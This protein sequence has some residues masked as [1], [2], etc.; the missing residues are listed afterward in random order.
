VNK[1]NE[2][3]EHAFIFVLFCFHYFVVTL[4]CHLG[5]CLLSGS[6]DDAAAWTWRD[7]LF[8]RRIHFLVDST[9]LYLDALQAHITSHGNKNKSSLPPL[10]SPAVVIKLEFL[11]LRKLASKLCHDLKF[12]KAQC[13]QYKT[14]YQQYQCPASC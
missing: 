1:W 3:N 2:S 13:E 9:A 10:P 11:Y 8:M 6:A 4:P 7:S 14:L 12:V 5:N